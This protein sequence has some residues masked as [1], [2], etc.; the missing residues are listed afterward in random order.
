MV[1]YFLQEFN[2]FIMNLMAGVNS[3]GQGIGNSTISLKEGLGRIF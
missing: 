2:D 1:C 3:E